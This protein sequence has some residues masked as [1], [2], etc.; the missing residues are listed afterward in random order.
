[1]LLDNPKNKKQ[2]SYRRKFNYRKDNI[3]FYILENSRTTSEI[4]EHCKKS[5]GYSA[6]QVIKVLLYMDSKD[7]IT[8]CQYCFKWTSNYHHEKYVTCFDCERN[9]KSQVSS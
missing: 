8:K 4:L 9:I 2:G 6:K 5:F 1:M 3:Y 7:I